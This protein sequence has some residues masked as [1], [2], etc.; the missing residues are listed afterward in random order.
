MPTC[1]SDSDRL[2]V[3]CR[4]DLGVGHRALWVSQDWG[5]CKSQGLSSALVGEKE[6]S[7][8]WRTG[9][10]HGDQVEFIKQ[11]REVEAGGWRVE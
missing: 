11:Q 6:G 2:C 3:P 1:S 8:L 10:Q 4:G 5:V 7:A 9:K